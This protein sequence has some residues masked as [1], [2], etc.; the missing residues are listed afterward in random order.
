MPT[1]TSVPLRTASPL[2]RTLIVGS[3]FTVAGECLSTIA[4]FLD[5]IGQA[6]ALHF[7]HQQQLEFEKKA[8]LD[9]DRLTAPRPE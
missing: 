1:E 5:D 6:H 8:Q 4:Q 3:L 7:Q 2:N 9:I